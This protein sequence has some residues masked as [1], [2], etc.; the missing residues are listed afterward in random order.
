MRRCPF[1]FRT[2]SAPAEFV[3]VTSE[4]LLQNFI[5]VRID[6]AVFEYYCAIEQRI[7][8]ASGRVTTTPIACANRIGI[9]E[10]GH[11]L[12]LNR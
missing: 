1:R 7:G 3:Y 12:G 8:N 4:L 9:C 6:R 5:S 10:I 2:H 11:K